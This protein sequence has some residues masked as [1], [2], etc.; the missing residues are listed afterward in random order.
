[1]ASLRSS[2]AV[3]SL[4]LFAAPVFAASADGTSA[5]PDAPA[6]ELGLRGSLRAKAGLRLPFAAPRDG[7]AGFLLEAPAFVEL[8]NSPG[9]DS[10]VPYELWRARI[11][12]GGGYRWRVKALRVDAL[13]LLEH[14][15]DHVTGPNTDTRSPDFGF[16]NFNDLALVGRVRRE[17][18]HPTFAQLTARLHLLTCTVSTSTCGA[19]LGW[20]GERTVEVSAEASQELTLDEGA[21]W[22]LF[23]SVSGDVMAATP[24]VAPARRVALRLG[25]L[26]RRSHDVLSLS[27]FGLAGTDVG[28]ARGPDTLQ[29]GVQLAWAL[30]D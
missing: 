27:L 2:R 6:V 11:A 13:A 12:L 17:V 7:E 20:A 10:V 15:S 8:H 30:A 9:N 1:M 26:W 28:Y 23:A 3:L 18:R 29:A 19:G 4:A 22:A 21:R 14:E 25:A 5:S 24:L 16:V